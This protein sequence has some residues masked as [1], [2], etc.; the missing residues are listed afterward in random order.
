MSQHRIPLSRKTFFP[1]ALHLCRDINYCVASLFLCFVSTFVVIIFSFVIT[2]FLR[3]AC[4]CY[5]DIKL[6]C[7]NIFLLSCTA[8]SE[9]YVATDFENVMIYD[10]CHYLNCLLKH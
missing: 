5:L 3:I 2:K 8:K 10:L 4:C 6:L 9:L 7:R 1:L